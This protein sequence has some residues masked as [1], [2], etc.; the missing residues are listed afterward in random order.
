MKSKCFDCPR[1]KEYIDLGG[2][3]NCKAKKLLMNTKTHMATC[4]VCGE[5]F[6]IPMAVEGFCFDDERRKRFTISIDGKLDKQQ[7][8]DFSKLIGMNGVQAYQLFK[9]NTPVEIV[10]VPMVLT[11]Q[12]QSFCHSIGVSISTQPAIDDYHLFEKCWRIQ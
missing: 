10:N 2:C 9:N 6:G 5:T 7:L 4:D 11:Y 1:T 8:L 12:I 3:L